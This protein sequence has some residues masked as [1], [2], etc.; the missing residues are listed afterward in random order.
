M[1]DKELGPMAAYDVVI[2][3]CGGW[4]L[5]ILKVLQD[6]GLRVLGIERA[7]I[8]QNLRLYRADA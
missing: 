2:V 8:C 3:G 7:E 1:L 5:A 4:G 6:L